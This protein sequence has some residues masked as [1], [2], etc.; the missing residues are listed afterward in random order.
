MKHIRLRLTAAAAALVLS[1]VGTF[2]FAQ[3]GTVSH[4]ESE[5]ASLK[6]TANISGA[7]VYLNGAYAGTAPLTVDGLVPGTY[8][9]TVKKSGYE[10][11]EIYADIAAGTEKS[12]YLELRLI[13]GILQISAQP[14]DSLVFIDGVQKSA[15]MSVRTFELPEGIHTVE[16]RAFGYR[17]D[18]Q[19]VY[20]PRN[21]ITALRVT[22]ERADFS[23]TAIR[24][25]PDTFNPQNPGVFGTCAVRFSVTAGGDGTITVFQNGGVI[26]TMPLKRFTTWEQSCEWDGRTDAGTSAPDGTYLITADVN[27]F[28]AGGDPVRQTSSA[29]VTINRSI[30]YPFASLSASGT[31]TGLVPS[32]RLYPAGTMSTVWRLGYGWQTERPAEYGVPLT[33]LFM[34]TPLDWLEYAVQAGFTVPE[35]G[36]VPLY[37]A[38]TVK[39]AYRAGA[40]NAGALLRY[41]YGTQSAALSAADSQL[42]LG[43]GAAAGITVRSVTANVS[44]ECIFGPERGDVSTGSICWKNGLSLRL[45]RG[46]FSAGIW[47]VAVSSFSTAADAPRDWFSGTS[48]GAD[49]AYVIPNTPVMLGIQGTGTVRPD[50][51]ARIA[52]A[53]ECTVFLR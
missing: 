23:A 25:T 30:S 48:F 26:R 20:V 10:T 50:G 46:S 36:E 14:A 51:S 43:L 53:L 5:R 39:A 9:I 34:H 41:G 15:A 19:S 7:A 21:T 42:G 11:K 24:V 13:T 1:A 45:N 40:F 3:D 28:T 2:C 29:S 32:A 37:A 12:F 33:M 44:S 47:G 31:G 38:G 27:G 6:I 17:P 4:T 16:I 8:R 35:S 18:M 49:A 52:F 22:L